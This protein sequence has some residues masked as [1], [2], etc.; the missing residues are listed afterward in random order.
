MKL[1]FHRAQRSCLR[2][3]LS[4]IHGK[5]LALGSPSVG[6]TSFTTRIVIPASFATLLKSIMIAV[7]LWVHLLSFRTNSM[8]ILAALYAFTFRS[9]LTSPFF[10]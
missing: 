4:L 9:L 10:V 3:S 8:L 2:Q 1:G 6:L 5:C 7:L